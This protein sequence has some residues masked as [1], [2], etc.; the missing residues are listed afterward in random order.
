MPNDPNYNLITEKMKDLIRLLLTPNPDKRPTIQ[1][2]EILIDN[3]NQLSEIELSDDALEI[4]KK[5]LL[6][7][8]NKQ[9]S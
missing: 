4:K 6:N 8:S 7:N 1:Q 3:F 2:L 5:Q 9:K